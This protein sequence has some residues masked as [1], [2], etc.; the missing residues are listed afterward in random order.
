MEKNRG[1]V[2]I[3]IPLSEVKKFIAID[4]VGGT[5]LYYLLK[6]PLHSMIAA[7]AGSMVGPYLIRL[8]MKRGKK[9]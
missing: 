2:V 3:V 4:L 1:F 8:S 6:L 7:T 9:K 5:L